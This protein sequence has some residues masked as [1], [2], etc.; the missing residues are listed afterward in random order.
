MIRTKENW[1]SG[2]TEYQIITSESIQSQ[3][4]MKASDYVMSL[5]MYQVE[6]LYMQLKEIVCQ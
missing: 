3:W 4:D 6:E 1:E 5:E 2:E